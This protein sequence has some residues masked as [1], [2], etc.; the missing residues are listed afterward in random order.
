M[1]AAKT[2]QS[3]GFRGGRGY[4]FFDPAALRRRPAASGRG[5]ETR[6]SE[7]ESARSEPA[8]RRT[9]ALDVPRHV[10]PGDVVRLWIFLDRQLTEQPSFHHR[11]VSLRRP[12]A[13]KRNKGFALLGASFSP[14]D[15]GGCSVLLVDRSIA[16]DLGPPSRSIRRAPFIY[17]GSSLTNP[18]LLQ[19]TQESA[20]RLAA[21]VSIKSV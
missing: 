13:K 11:D 3:Y 18:R 19:E 4:L 1:S 8:V 16:A 9:Q 12:I 6:A 17:D 2:I 7:N 21:G 5:G 20:D 15:R 14:E 10:S